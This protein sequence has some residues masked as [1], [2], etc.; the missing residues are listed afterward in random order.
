LSPK[1]QNK[2][3]EKAFELSVDLVST[4][5]LKFT[6]SISTLVGY[7]VLVVNG[8]LNPTSMETPIKYFVK[9][10]I[11]VSSTTSCAAKVYWWFFFIPSNVLRVI[12]HG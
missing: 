9:L 8:A 10:P 2:S 4:V 7:T 11:A 1:A 5:R 3:D 6:N 12:L